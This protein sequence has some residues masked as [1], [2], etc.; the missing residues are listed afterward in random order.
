MVPLNLN[1]ICWHSLGSSDNIFKN[2]LSKIVQ[3]Y[4]KLF[5]KLCGHVSNLFRWSLTCIR[6][7]GS[8]PHHIKKRERPHKSS[9]ELERS[10]I[11]V[12][13]LI[14]PIFS[15]SSKSF[16]S[17]FYKDSV[18]MSMIFFSAD[19]WPVAELQKTDQMKKRKN[20]HIICS[21]EPETVSLQS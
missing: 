21:I 1:A 9:V 3:V 18:V 14:Q 6:A 7:S 5:Q 12:L 19:L 20:D 8:W 10:L 15:K 13:G 2:L 16:W 11:A 17:F 4:F